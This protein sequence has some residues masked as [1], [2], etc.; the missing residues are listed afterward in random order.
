MEESRPRN[1]PSGVRVIRLPRVAG[2]LLAV[3]LLFALGA[4]SL[5]AFFVGVSA[6]VL[7]P[8]LRRRGRDAHHPDG[9]TV[10]LERGAYRR[11][12]DVRALP[13]GERR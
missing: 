11:I 8:R 3:P 1:A 7:A 6:L 13:D 4:V 9:R 5:A 2:V 12:D 10:T